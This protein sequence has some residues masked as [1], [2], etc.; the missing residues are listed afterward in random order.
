MTTCLLT[1]NE[2]I[3]Q[4]L[5]S[6]HVYR[7]PSTQDF[8]D[9]GRERGGSIRAPSPVKLL[10]NLFGGS[11][12]EGF[13]GGPRKFQRQA[14][15]LGEIPR[16]VP[17]TQ[18]SRPTTQDSA[19]SWD[20]ATS[21]LS[22]PLS[23]TSAAS[24][25]LLKLE[26]TLAAY[27]LALHARKGNVVGKTLRA[28]ATADE[29][30]VNELYNVMLENPDNHQMAA[31]SSVDVLFA[32]FEKFVKAAWADKMGPI[33]PAQ[34]MTEMQSQSEKLF[35]VDFEDYFR[36]TFFQLSPQ[37]QRG[38]KAIVRLLADLLD[39][40]GNDSDRGILTMAFA[41]IL[42][43]QGNPHDFFSLLDRFVDDV[44]SLFG[45]II[46][47]GATTP[48]EDPTISHRH[49]RTANASSIS[50]NTSSLRKRF[51]LSTLSRENSK[52]EQESK[53]GSV[54]RTLSKTGRSNVNQPATLPRGSLI[55]SQSTDERVRTSPPRRPPSR[56][57]PTVLGAFSFEDPL[58][59][60]S[61]FMPGS[62]L[63]TIG[64]TSSPTPGN[65]S[66]P[67]KKRRSSLSDLKTLQEAKESPS[68][69]T[70]RTP[71]SNGT[72]IRR[73]IS[74]QPSPR[75]P[76][77]TKIPISTPSSRLGSPGPK[78]NSPTLQRP[79]RKEPITSV[80]RSATKRRNVSGIPTLK[81]TS[82]NSGA[83]TEHPGS[84]NSAKIPLSHST[85]TSPTKL[86]VAANTPVKSPSVTT[87]SPKKLRMQSPQKL[88]ERLQNE[89]KAIATTA[90]SFETEISSIRA[91]M[92]AVSCKDT[93]TSHAARP[94]TGT[95][96]SPGSPQ[97]PSSH[98]QNTSD[99]TSLSARLGSLESTHRATISTLTQRL[100][101]L[102]SDVNTSLQVS[103]SKARKLDDLYKEANAENEALY[104]R[105]ND[106]LAKIL[107]NVKNSPDSGVE[108]LKK[109]LAEAQ[110]DAT[111]GKREVARLKREVVGLRAQLRDG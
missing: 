96:A 77:P 100:E 3:L 102:S 80:E 31:Q 72:V 30:A 56:D 21:K 12:R 70:P 88:R 1:R 6:L 14:P 5:Q 9:Q 42:I 71:G 23:S 90:T 106:E 39:G 33:V 34:T 44:D 66:G 84:G 19:K 94:C 98:S 35:P 4:I 86:P 107:K 11:T 105:F 13:S 95:S 26:E 15:N 18:T 62:P 110:E 50:S 99:L 47:V 83:L 92:D 37:N 73:Q 109:K 28:R 108:V 36:S 38:F 40:T 65:A 49:E 91:E 57:R 74:L 64:E 17:P 67:R 111:K 46:D 29:L 81:P 2:Q 32:S 68:S 75:T 27:V 104:A 79:M 97:G 82:S 87:G 24:N 41:E 59:N 55:R 78:E 10:S 58:H 103:E 22:V 85:H 54:W 20:D 43:N 61:P 53:G 93:Q 76:S 63:G 8:P 60:R 89:Q 16:M 51:G 25:A 48:C 45:D 69:W 7:E 52:S 101:S